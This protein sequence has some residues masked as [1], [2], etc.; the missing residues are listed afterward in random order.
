LKI[1]FAALS[2]RKVIGDKKGLADSYN[3]IGLIYMN[4]GNYSKALKNHLLTL[5]IKKKN[6]KTCCDFRKI[7]KSKLERQEGKQETM[8]S[9]RIEWNL[10]QEGEN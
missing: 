7:C 5:K 10:H 6:R 9:V 8:K 1:N 3:N 4:L 2:I